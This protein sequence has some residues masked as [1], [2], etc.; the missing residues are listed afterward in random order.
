MHTHKFCAMTLPSS[1]A[2]PSRFRSSGIGSLDVSSQGHTETNPERTRADTS[3]TFN[4]YT[5]R[6]QNQESDPLPSCCKVEVLLI[7]TTP[8]YMYMY[9]TLTQFSK[10]NL[11]YVYYNRAAK[12]SLFAILLFDP[13]LRPGTVF[14]GALTSLRIIKKTK[15]Y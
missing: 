9:A 5:E 3:R 7:T 13:E 8:L 1:G 15:Q 12:R 11:N 10:F 4:V 6:L 14:S 2:Y